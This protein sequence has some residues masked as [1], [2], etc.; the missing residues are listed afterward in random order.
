MNFYPYKLSD[1]KFTPL[2]SLHVDF[3]SRHVVNS[4]LFF[5]QNCPLLIPLHNTAVL[6]KIC[7]FLINVVK[8]YANPYEIGPFNASHGQHRRKDARER[9]KNLTLA[10]SRTQVHGFSSADAVTA[11]PR[12]PVAGHE[13]LSL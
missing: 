11:M 1:L 3:Y 10:G 8:F 7:H 6:I 12:V 5:L 9:I 4:V 2:P 13:F